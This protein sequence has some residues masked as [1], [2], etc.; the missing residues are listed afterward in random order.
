MNPFTILSL[1]QFSSF[2][3]QFGETVPCVWIVESQGTKLTEWF[4]PS[5][6]V[7]KSFWVEAEVTLLPGIWFSSHCWSLIFLP[8]QLPV[9][10]EIIKWGSS[11]RESG[12][13]GKHKLPKLTQEEV[14]CW[15]R[16]ITSKEFESVIKYNVYICICAWAKSLQSS[17]ILHD[18]MDCSMP[19]S[20]VHWIL[21]IRIQE[22]VAMPS[23]RGSSQP[24]NWTWI[25]CIWGRIFTISVTWEA[26]I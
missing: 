17:P 21:Q 26:Y 23:Y 5:P 13:R 18:P 7:Q 10:R 14:E 8:D 3:L 24:R 11:G 1:F 19:G 4:L 20:S 22:W 2:I 25:S 12:T 9:L 15:N 16:T 6:R